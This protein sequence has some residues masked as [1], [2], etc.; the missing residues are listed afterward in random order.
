M[1]TFSLLDHEFIPHHEIMD[2][3]E[4]RTVL[5]HFN[6]EREQLPKLKVTDPIAQ[7]IDAAPGDV[8]KITRN[9]QTAGEAL[10]YRYVIE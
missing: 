6:V 3:D 1:N 10:Y 9:S 8:V 2:E 7:E 5:K 4:L